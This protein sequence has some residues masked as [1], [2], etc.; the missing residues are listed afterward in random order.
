MAT[1]TSAVHVTGIHGITGREYVNCTLRADTP[2]QIERADSVL[3]SVTL[4]VAGDDDPTALYRVHA[5]LADLRDALDASG[6]G[7]LTAA[8]ARTEQE[9]ANA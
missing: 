3:R 7:D 6:I 8:L 4:L 1:L 2:V 5:N 9:I